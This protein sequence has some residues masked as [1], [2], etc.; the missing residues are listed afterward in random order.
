MIFRELCRNHFHD[1]KLPQLNGYWCMV[2]Q[3]IALGRRFQHRKIVRHPDLR[4]RIT[5]CLH[6]GWSPKQIAGRMRQK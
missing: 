4:A 2:A 5:S 3:R 6:A 1:A